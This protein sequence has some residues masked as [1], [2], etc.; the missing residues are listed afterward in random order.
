M[1]HYKK[2]CLS[3]FS[4]TKSGVVKKTPL[5]GPQHVTFTSDPG[6]LQEMVD[7]AMH[8]TLINQSELLENTI[9]NSLIKTL[10]E[11]LG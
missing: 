7:E 9:Q 6:K 10:K 1:E 2:L 3:S 4:R 8:R 11:G 5:P